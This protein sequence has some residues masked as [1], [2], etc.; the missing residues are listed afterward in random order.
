MWNLW[1]IL[2]NDTRFPICYENNIITICN[3]K[4]SPLTL[5]EIR[6]ILKVMEETR[7]KKV[8]VIKS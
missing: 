6:G 1:L 7:V 8:E 3:N 5:E 2:D 4:A